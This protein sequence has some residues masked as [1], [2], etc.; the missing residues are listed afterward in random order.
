MLPATPTT[1]AVIAAVLDALTVTAS[2]GLAAVPSVPP[3]M[4]AIA[5][6]R[7]TFVDS[8]PPP[9]IAIAGRRPRDRH[10]DRDGERRDVDAHRVG[11]GH[12]Q[13]RA[14]GGDERDVAEPGVDVVVDG[15]VGEREADGDRCGARRGEAG[16]DRAGLGVGDDD[17]RRGGRDRDPAAGGGHRRRA[18]HGRLDAGGDRVVGP[19]AADRRGHAARGGGR[20]GDAAAST[21]AVIDA[22]SL[23]RT[24][25]PVA[26]EIEPPVTVA[27]ACDAPGRQVVVGAPDDV[28]GDGDAD[29]DR[30]RAVA[31]HRQR[32]RDGLDRGRDRR[33][34]ANW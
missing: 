17:R 29:R 23:A 19:Q 11:G 7:I 8:D 1:V 33:A 5:E 3:L 31:A 34:A 6:P 32:D 15:V 18:G 16:G 12:A 20:H 30:R 25:T 24:S 13:R 4:S 9:A 14:A 21:R 26:A 27:R 28:A 10:R 2:T 22:L